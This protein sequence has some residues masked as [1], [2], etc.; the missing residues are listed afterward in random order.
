MH[1]CNMLPPQLQTFTINNTK[2]EIYVPE[3]VAIQKEY[4]NKKEAAYWAQ[5]W[6]AAIGL[7]KFLQTHPVYIADKKILELAAGLGLPGLFAAGT[8]GQVW[9]TDRDGE[10]VGY[11]QQSIQHLQLLNAQ[12]MVLDWKNAASMLL[13]DVLLLS[14]VNYEPAVFDELLK[15]LDHFLRNKVTIIISTPQRLVAKAFINRLLPYCTMQWN[16][17]IVLNEND[18]GV[19]IFVL[20]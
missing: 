13:P 5:I 7:C 4:L 20:E 9:I 12:A 6:P 11:V 19:S 14:D 18:T 10:A 16:T 15:V 2:L 1:L 8:A 3:V 17:N